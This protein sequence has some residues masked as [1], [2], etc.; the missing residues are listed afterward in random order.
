LKLNYMGSQSLIAQLFFETL[1][2]FGT[3]R[4]QK[5]A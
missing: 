1:L 2:C 4:E 5:S 3:R